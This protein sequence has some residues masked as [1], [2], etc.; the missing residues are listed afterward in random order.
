MR[1]DLLLVRPPSSV[2]AQLTRVLTEHG[3]QVRQVRCDRDAGEIGSDVDLCVTKAKTPAALALARRYHEAG[4]ATFN[5][6]EVTELC[7]D[8][9]ATTRVLESAGVPVPATFTALDP[10]DLAPLLAD[11]P[12]VVKPYRGSQGAGIEVVERP[13][14]LSRIDHGGDPILAQRYLEPDGRD[15]KIYRIGD[16]VFCVERVWPPQ[17]LAD[18]VG[19][20]VRL[21]AGIESVARACGEALG[22]DTYGVDVIEHHGEPWVVDL[23]SFPGFKGVPEAGRR[24]AERVLREVAPVRR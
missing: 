20:L 9:I 14:Q 19:R 8:K 7:R 22:I 5:P 2:F 6:Y 21:P 23:S 18:K 12:L 15:R 24:L 16:E 4:V 10:T 11:G 1:I 13:E 3:A 17:S